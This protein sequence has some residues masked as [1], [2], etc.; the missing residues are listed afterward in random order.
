MKFYSLLTVLI[1]SSFSVIAQTAVQQSVKHDLSKPA[2]V[3][4]E[5]K[6]QMKDQHWKPRP[7]VLFYG[8]QQGMNY[9]IKNDGVSFQLSRVDS[10]RE[11]EQRPG[12]PEKSNIKVPDQIS[13]YRVDAQ[14]IGYNADF[15]VEQ[16]SALDG[17]NN[18]YNVPEGVEPALFVKQYES[19]TLKNVW[20]GIDIHYYGTDGQLET[21]YLVAPGADYR[22]IKMEIRGAELSTSSDGHLIMKTPFG[23]IQEGELKV[24]QGGERLQAFWEIEEQGRVSFTIPDYNPALALRI[25][26]L[27]RLW[28]TYYG[29]SG[30]DQGNVVM[31]DALGNVYLAGITQSTS[32]IASGG[33]QNS[34]GGGDDAF[35]VKFDSLGVRQWATYYGGSGDD[36]AFS[37]AIDASGLIFLSGQTTSIA[38]IASTGHQN[39]FGGGDDAFL[40]K[41]NTNGVRQWATYYGG[42][43]YDGTYGSFTTIDASGNVYLAGTTTSTSAIATGSHQNTIGGGADAFLVKFN[44]NGVRQWGTYYGGSGADIGRYTSIDPFGDVYLAGHTTSSSAI[45]S[46]GHQNVSGGGVDAFLVKFNSSGVR[47]WGTYYGGAG[48]TQGYSTTTDASG[49]VYLAGRV[50]FANTTGIAFMGHQNAF[51]GGAYDAFLVKFN[52]SGV[53]QWGS[54][55]GGSGDEYS[56]FASTDTRGNVYLSGYTNSTTAIASGGYQDVFGGGLDAFLVKFSF[57]GIR[58]WAT[59]YGGSSNEFSGYTA[60]SNFAKV[61][62][63]GF[64]GSAS[65]I[66]SVGHQN[67]YGGGGDSFLAKFFENFISIQPLASV[68]SCANSA[69]SLSLTASAT[70][71]T[72][73]WQLKSPASTLFSNINAGGAN[74]FSGVNSSALTIGSPAG[75]DGYSFRC[76]VSDGI[77][78]EISDTSQLTVYPIPSINSHPLNVNVCLGNTANFFLSASGTGLTYQWQY[79]STS[80]G[81]WVN[82]SNGSAYSG[83]TTSSLQ[84]LNVSNLNGYQYRCLVTN[85]NAC[86]VS[87]NAATLTVYANPV[88]SLQPSSTTAC[89]T[90]ST[91]LNLTASGTGLSY[92]WQ[93]RTGTTGAWINCSN[94]VVY[95]GSMS[96]SLQILNLNGLNAYQYSCI[97]TNSNACSITSN[98]VVLTVYDPPSITVQPVSVSTCVTQVSNFTLTA[99]GTSLT[100]QWQYRAGSSSTWANCSNGSI[101]SGSITSTLQIINPSGLNNYQFRCITSNICPASVTSN[102][103]S[104][105]VYEVPVI[106]TQ[107]ISASVCSSQIATFALAASG[108]GLVYQWQNRPSST[109]TWVNCSNGPLYSGS[110]TNTLQVLNTASLNNYQYRCLVSNICPTQATSNTVSLTVYTSPTA[111]IT[112][113]GA[114]ANP[115]TINLGD[116][117]SLSLSGSF[118]STP[119]ITWTPSAGLSSTTVSDPIAYPSSTTTYTATF[120]NTYGCTQS[121]SQQVVVNSL[122]NSGAISVVSG[123]GV[124]SYSV[125][126]TLQVQVR[127]IGVTN[128]YAAYARLRYSGALAPYMTYVGYTAGT[129]LGTG[130]A[131]ISTPPVA[132]GTY[133]YDF[134]I[135]KIGA[136]AGYAG[137]GTLYTFYFKPNNIPSNLIGS[138]VCFYVDN[139]SITSATTGASLGLVNQGPSCFSFTNQVNVWPGDLDNNKT[140]NTADLLKIGIFYNNTGPVRPNASL[141]WVAQPATLWGLNT[142]SPNSDAY[143]VFVDGNGDG[144]INNA[145]QASVGFNMSRIHARPIR[146]D[147]PLNE[148]FFQRTAV[149][150]NLTVIPSPGYVNSNQLPQQVELQV[151]LA[152]SGGTLN[153]LYGISF[154]IAVDTTV[155]DLQNTTFDYVGSIFGTPSQDF[156]NIEYV[157]NGIVSVGMTRFNN[158]AIN[159][160]GLLC[161]IRLNTYPTLNL[162]AA[163]LSFNGTVVAANDEVGN[164]YVIGPATVQIPYGPTADISTATTEHLQV[165]VYPNPAKEE[166]NLLMGRQVLI[167]EIKVL[168]EMGRVVLN[169][170]PNQLMSSYQLNIADLATGIYTLQLTTNNEQLHKRFVKGGN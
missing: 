144:I 109:G 13:T 96:N 160:N 30:T 49:N 77:N 102:I 54:Y 86:S 89:L 99:T 91:S 3:F 133:G 60:T 111:S 51:G 1:I 119:N 83:S 126:D 154:D 159:G 11:E 100:Y 82:C 59:Y 152:N 52:S 21:D 55:Y 104:L 33:H 76:L 163:T 148:P 7:D 118:S 58:Q 150:G 61:Y 143:K 94:G 129:I 28:G 34:F 130:A 134:G 75:L 155:F 9:Y 10:W 145:D 137:T 6:G 165:M 112:A 70:G 101:Y 138:Q 46:G 170:A 41:F 157:A 116:A 50:N 62:L 67:N 64:T 22:Q 73:Q 113:D 115:A 151:S 5:N 142:S 95:S 80:T 136:A 164:P 131:V 12:M 103:V 65:S 63:A 16:G 66:S 128:I 39:T 141:Q 4:E 71:L 105:T 26:P 106:N 107:P 124:N 29:G 98:S 24:Y 37:V 117:T 23:E 167:R 121:V 25:D 36:A 146:P 147:N 123:T 38:S 153:N 31:T 14:W 110:T 168:D 108:A 156:L 53:R 169:Q 140:V 149:A 48:E 40:V 72:Y 162:S 35:L 90:Q 32:S 125:F 87:S 161:K 139:L 122:P 8:N 93:Y 47:Q 114:S 92:Q 78:S 43:D 85:S 88:I 19:V 27:I 135:S 120:T 84:V 56:G 68:I 166:L 79:R 74:I 2:S 44:T 127:L 18:Y 69:V 20:N 158:P 15:K 42:S 97:I 17:Y 57:S 81:T 132:S 45:A